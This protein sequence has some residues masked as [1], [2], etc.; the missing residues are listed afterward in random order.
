MYNDDHHLDDIDEIEEMDPLDARYEYDEERAR[1]K[2][3]LILRR[4]RIRDIEDPY[5][6]TFEAFVKIKHSYDHN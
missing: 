3:L 6:V 4:R 5:D 1:Q 2:R